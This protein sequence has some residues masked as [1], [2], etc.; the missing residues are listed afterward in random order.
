VHRSVCLAALLGVVVLFSAAPAEPQTNGES[1]Q[2]LLARVGRRVEEYFARAASVVA[3]EKV[4]LQPIGRDFTSEGFARR[5]V[6]EL[7]VSWNPPEPSETM[8][9]VSVLRQLVSVN[10]RP[11]RDDGRRRKSE[12][13][14]ACL[15]PKA[16][17]PEPLEMLLDARRGDYAFTSAGPGRSDGRPALMIDYR[18]TLEKSPP[19][20]TWQSETCGSIEMPGFLRGRLWVDAVSGDVL[21]LDEALQG[22]PEV[23]VP[24]DKVDKGFSP[25]LRVERADS[26]IRYKVV[27][28]T[29]PE[30]HLLLPASVESLTIII[31]SGTP[32]RRTVHTYSDYKRFL[33]GGRIVTRP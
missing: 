22:Y 24:R 20:M 3:T 33:T 4:T 31:G 23:R 7:R 12:E 9:K 19:T 6:Y 28:F 27:S 18:S 30:E 17:S 11:P 1:L 26:S 29:D 16:V 8:P 32:R 10:G 2:D 25:L 5:L 21:R 15:D 13:D 14:A